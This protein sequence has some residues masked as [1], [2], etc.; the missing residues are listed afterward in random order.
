MTRAKDYV[1]K[2]G[3]AMKKILCVLAVFAVLA[4]LCTIPASAKTERKVVAQSDTAT[5]YL[6]NGDKFQC[7]HR[8]TNAGLTCQAAGRVTRITTD[9]VTLWV[10]INQYQTVARSRVT[11]NVVVGTWVQKWLWEW[12]AVVPSWVSVTI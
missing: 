10:G 9:T 12:N 11:G 8:W 6:K 5:I 2:E 4:S 7:N 1:I 3:K